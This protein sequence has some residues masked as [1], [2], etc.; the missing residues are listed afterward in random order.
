MA[1]YGDRVPGP[2][3]LAGAQHPRVEE[4]HDRPQLGQPVLDGSSGQGDPVARAQPF[5][6]FRGLRQ[7][8][9]DRLGLVQ[10]HPPPLVTGEFLDVTGRGGVGGDD[11]VGLAQ[12]AAE[13][14]PTQAL[15][16]M[17]R[18][19]PEAGRE[20]GGLPLPVADQ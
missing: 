12:L 1:L 2:E 16:P 7:A 3:L 15:R 9:L 5:R 13:L 19:D 18:V 20:P 17:V 10:H 11:Q 6:R 14:F 8:V 4:V